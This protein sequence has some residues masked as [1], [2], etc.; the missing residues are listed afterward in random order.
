MKVTS[1]H[2]MDAKVLWIDDKS[3]VVTYTWMGQGTYMDRPM[4]P[5]TFASTVWTQRNG[6]WVAVFHQ[7]SIAA[8]R[9][10]APAKKK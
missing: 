3:A 1:H 7:E 4:P 9:P 5:Q 10:A 6:K 2:M 8:I